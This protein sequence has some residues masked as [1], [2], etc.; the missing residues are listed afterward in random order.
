MMTGSKHTPSIARAPPLGLL[1]GL[2]DPVKVAAK[3]ERPLVQVA[4]GQCGQAPPGAA[5]LQLP[6]T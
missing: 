4:C 5:G 2:Y 3:V 1:D 6:R